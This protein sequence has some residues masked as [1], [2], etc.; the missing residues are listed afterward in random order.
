MLCH[1]A[2]HARHVFN[3]RFAGAC[4]PPGLILKLHKLCGRRMHIPLRKQHQALGDRFDRLCQFCG[5]AQHEDQVQRP[6]N[7]ADNDQNDS[8]SALLLLIMSHACLNIVKIVSRADVPP[9]GFKQL[10]IGPLFKYAVL[11]GFCKIEFRKIAAFVTGGN[12]VT[13]IIIALLILHVV[14][15]LAFIFLIHMYRAQ[16]VLFVRPQIAVP[17]IVAGV[18]HDRFRNLAGLLF[19]DLPRLLPLF[20]RL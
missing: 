9:I 8:V 16:A 20:I 13:N 4:Q 6:D 18:A 10:C 7:H 15:H 11:T 17:V 1:V 3:E 19:G 5:P 12:Q 14:A 2:D